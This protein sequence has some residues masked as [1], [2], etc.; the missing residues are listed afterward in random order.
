MT[1]TCTTS[2]SYTHLLED[3]DYIER[4]KIQQRNWIGRSTG[5]EITFQTNIGDEVTVYT[6]LL[7]T[8][9]KKMLHATS[10][11]CVEDTAKIAGIDLTDKA[12]W[13]Q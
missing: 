7:Y 2:V 8:S 10:V 5:A 9:S 1:A 13:R 6:C 4:V 11:T 12:F 3:V